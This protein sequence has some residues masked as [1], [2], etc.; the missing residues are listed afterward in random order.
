VPIFSPQAL[1]TDGA[2][3]YIGG[4]INGTDCAGGLT[5]NIVRISPNGT[6]SALGQ[7]MPG[8][9]VSSIATRGQS[10]YIGGYNIASAGGLPCMGFAIWSLATQTWLAPIP[11][12]SVANSYYTFSQYRIYSMAIS[13]DGSTVVLSGWPFYTASWN[14]ANSSWGYFGSNDNNFGMVQLY[15]VQSLPSLGLVGWS[16]SAVPPVLYRMTNSTSWVPL[17]NCLS[18]AFA[19]AGA[20][21]FFYDI[22]L[23]EIS[24]TIYFSS[25]STESPLNVETPLIGVPT[26]GRYVPTMG[27]CD[28]PGVGVSGAP[29]AMIS[30]GGSLYVS[31]IRGALRSSA[32]AYN[33]LISSTT[34]GYAKWNGS[35]WSASDLGA[36][37]CYAQPITWNGVL[38]CLSYGPFSSSISFLPAVPSSS[39]S[40]SPSPSPSSTAAGALFRTL[41]RTDLVGAL[42][43]AGFNAASESACRQACMAASGCDAYAFAAGVFLAFSQ[44]PQAQG[45][46]EPA[47]C[48]L[49]ANVTALV[50]NNMMVSGVLS[51]R[52]S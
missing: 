49:L 20:P 27:I 14:T 47:P 18:T 22:N 8:S 17:A 21:I 10:V 50:P 43:G 39:T 51:A 44:Q 6:M 31:G 5:N 33:D 37:P 48:Y 11:P 12:S 28:I 29:T 9:G 13:A 34:S 52:Y 7:G 24:G 38:Y 36:M 15:A 3:I 46:G 41:P 30:V 2:D 19:T 16:E 23:I 45:S 32:T 40:P 35:A 4:S 42:V 25:R 1:A 26:I